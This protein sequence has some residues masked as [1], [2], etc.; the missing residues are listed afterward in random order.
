MRKIK[1]KLITGE[2][3]QLEQRRK[4]LIQGTAAVQNTIANEEEVTMDERKAIT[5]KEA[6]DRA[7]NKVDQSKNTSKNVVTNIEMIRCIRSE[8]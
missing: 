6:Y 4:E 8:I 3:H 1:R 7:I 2:K 5:L